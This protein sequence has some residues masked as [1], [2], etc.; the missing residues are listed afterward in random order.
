MAQYCSHTYAWETTRAATCTV[1]GMQVYRCTKCKQLSNGNNNYRTI[2]AKHTFITGSNNERYC[3]VCNTP[4]YDY[5]I[6]ASTHYIST[7]GSDERKKAKGGE[8]GDS[9]GEE[10]KMT[11][12]FSSINVSPSNTQ[13]NIKINVYRY[14]ANSEV[15]KKLARLSIEAALNN[16]I[17]YDQDERTTYM[18]ELKKVGW[19]PKKITTK[20]EQDCAAGV[21]TNV[22]AVGNLLNLPKLRDMPISATGAIGD[23]L[24]NAGYTKVYSDKSSLSTSEINSLKAGDILVVRYQK[25][26]DKGDWVWKGHAVVNVTGN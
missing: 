12:S 2:T 1:D 26:N 23:S 22:I 3:K 10:W 8:A 5:Y 15:G 21:S 11:T 14:T 6:N 16:N 17:G 7:S 20:C 13:K 24:T 9:T 18:T 25:K 4:D 19:D